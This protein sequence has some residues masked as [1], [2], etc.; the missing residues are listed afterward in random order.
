MTDCF[1]LARTSL[2]LR[3]SNVDL[4]SLS[5]DRDILEYCWRISDKDVATNNPTRRGAREADTKTRAIISEDREIPISMN[6]KPLKNS[7]SLDRKILEYCWELSDSGSVENLCKELDEE[8]PVT[9]KFTAAAKSVSVSSVHD[10]QDI[11]SHDSGQIVV[12]C[13]KSRL[14]Y[15]RYSTAP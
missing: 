7:G 6:A 15:A 1:A 3:S 5:F 4:S 8:G 14:A 2:P 9:L 12:R 10:L 11:Q 13:S